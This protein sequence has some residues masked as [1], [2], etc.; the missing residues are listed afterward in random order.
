VSPRP[1]AASSIAAST[2]STSICGWIDTPTRWASSASWRRVGSSVP[3]LASG[4]ISGAC[5]SASIVIGLRTCD[6]SIDA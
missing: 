1:R 5:A 6:G 4:R 2:S 3:Q